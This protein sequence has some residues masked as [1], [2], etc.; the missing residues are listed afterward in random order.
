MGAILQRISKMTPISCSG[1]LSPSIQVGILALDSASQPVQLD[2]TENPDV[3][4][5]AFKDLRS[6]GPFVLNGRTISAYNDRF[7]VRQDETIKVCHQNSSNLSIR[8]ES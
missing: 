7:K 1:G 6:R 3:L 2:F 5:E 4:F 8:I